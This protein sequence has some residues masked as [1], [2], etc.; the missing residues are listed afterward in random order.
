MGRPVKAHEAQIAWMTLE[1]PDRL[2]PW[3]TLPQTPR[4]QLRRASPPPQLV[5]RAAA[6]GHGPDTVYHAGAVVSHPRPDPLA[7]AWPGRLTAREQR[8][9]AARPVV[10]HGQVW[11]FSFV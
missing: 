4:P 11:F 2:L 5:V 10:Y 7:P 3:A 6:A 9:T 1:A 8:Y